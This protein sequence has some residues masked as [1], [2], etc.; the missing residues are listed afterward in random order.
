MKFSIADRSVRKASD[1][2]HWRYEGVGVGDRGAG[3]GVVHGFR[4]GF[5]ELSVKPAGEALPDED[6]V[7]IVTSVPKEFCAAAA[8]EAAIQAC[9]ILWHSVFPS[10]LSH[11]S[12]YY[13]YGYSISGL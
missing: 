2:C 13:I 12:G 7:N 1:T 10:S 6:S 8:P 5:P 9:I 4:G 11:P 3:G